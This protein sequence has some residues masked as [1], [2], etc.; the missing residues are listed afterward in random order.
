M[1]G[2]FG[3]VLE[4]MI[5]FDLYFE[6]AIG[7]RDTVTYGFDSL[8]SENINPAFGEFNL[9]YTAFDSVFEVRGA[10]KSG[11]QFQSNPIVAGY[12]S[13]FCDVYP[14]VKYQSMVIYPK[15]WP[16]TI[17][18]GSSYVEHEC[19]DWTLFTRHWGYL[20]HPSPGYTDIRY[21]RKQSRLTIYKEYMQQTKSY[22]NSRLE[23]IE[24]GIQDTVYN[25]WVGLSGNEATSA[26]SDPDFGKELAVFPNPA[27]DVLQVQLPSGLAQNEIAQIAC[28]DI[29]GKRVQLSAWKG[30]DQLLELDVSGLPA[31]TYQ[32]VIEHELGHPIA[33]FR[34]VKME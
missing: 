10:D 13:N 26:I 24:G 17:R 3:Q 8:A 16:V 27:V 34:F 7:N 28:I 23:P 30:T 20:F 31:G 29:L 6:D 25:M 1:N 4:P 33:Y 19:Y 2:A 18:W 11:Y 12:L 14:I 21:L 32:G 15:H 22:Y 9:R 5:K